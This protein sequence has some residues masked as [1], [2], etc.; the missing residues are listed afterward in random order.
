MFRRFPRC[1]DERHSFFLSV[2]WP[3]DAGLRSFLFHFERPE[4]RAYRAEPGPLA[5]RIATHGIDAAAGDMRTERDAGRNVCAGGVLDAAVAAGDGERG[6]SV[7]AD[8]RRPE[9]CCGG[10]E[11]Y[12]GDGE[13]GDGQ[14]RKCLSAG[15]RSDVGHRALAVDLLCT[16]HRRRKQHGDGDLQPGSDLSGYKGAG[17]CGGR[18]P[19][20]DGREE[21]EECDQQQ[22]GCNDDRRERADCGGEYGCDLD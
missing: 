7:G 4:R 5:A 9:R 16:G 6:L 10:L 12:N 20:C 14:R 21:R 1:M 18:E 19:G 11:R 8:G 3:A 13:I 17:I 2:L 22:W 15:D